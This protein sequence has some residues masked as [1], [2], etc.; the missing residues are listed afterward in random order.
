MSLHLAK[1]PA[2]Y[3]RWPYAGFLILY[4]LFIVYV[5]AI[6][7][8][9]D[10]TRVGLQRHLARAEFVPFLDKEWGQLSFGDAL[11]N[12]FLFIPLGIFL[13]NWRRGASQ[14]NV[15]KVTRRNLWLCGSL[16]SVAI[17]ILQL[18]LDERTSSINDVMMNSAGAYIGLRLASA[19]P[20]LM[21]QMLQRIHRLA[22]ERL[23]FVYWGITMAAQ[24]VWALLPLDFSLKLESL[25]RQFLRWEFSWRVFM[26]FGSNAPRNRNWLYSFPPPA[27]LAPKL[28]VTACLGVL[29]GALTVFCCNYY[30]RH[31][32]RV[33]WSSLVAVASFYPV[34]AVLQ[35]IVQSVHPNILFPLAGLGGVAIGM[36]LMTT[37]LLL[38][39]SVVKNERIRV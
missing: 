33:F 23:A 9:L 37:G 39:Q 12:I 29:L 34:L 32:P 25:Q 31:M 30:W 21:R 3:S 20:D 5:V 2:G 7:F 1:Q 24:T 26:Q 11:G 19:Q 14:L 16:F 36:L 4:S 8:R 27:N 28:L 17:E 15:E 18:F 38:W 22:H 10:L 35:F 6:P 13:Y